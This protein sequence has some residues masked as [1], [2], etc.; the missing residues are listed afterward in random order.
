MVFQANPTVYPMA[1]I[2]GL[3]SGFTSPI[4]ATFPSWDLLWFPDVSFFTKLLLNYF[5]LWL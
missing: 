4:A 2:P 3:G 5:S 1:H